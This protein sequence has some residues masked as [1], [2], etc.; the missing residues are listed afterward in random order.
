[1][2][3]YSTNNYRK[4]WEH[5]NGPIPKDEEGRSYEIHHIDGNHSN[6]HIDNLQCVSIQEHYDIHF[7]QN[8]TYACLRISQKMKMSSESISELATRLNNERWSDPEY[9]ERLLEINNSPQIRKLRSDNL[10]DCWN[11][12]EFRDNMIAIRNSPKYLEQRSQ[13]S[14]E[15]WS[16]PVRREQQSDTLK[17][18]WSDPKKRK[19]HSDMQRKFLQTLP[20]FYCE[21]CNRHIRSQHNWNQHLRSKQHI[22]NS[23]GS[24]SIIV[25][26]PV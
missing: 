4:I 15:I 7:R 1:M 5:F 19:E 3:I 18:I 21:C 22:Q 11:N 9:R 10:K 26:E 24:S 25:C 23:S 16:D 13:I 6:N 2:D 12:E 8:D 20:L 14:T 17:T